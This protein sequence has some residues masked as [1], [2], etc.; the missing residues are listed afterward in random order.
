MLPEGR[1][2]EPPAR[3]ARAAPTTA[4]PA[5]PAFVPPQPLRGP[6]GA[7]SGCRTPSSPTTA[8]AATASTCGASSACPTSTHL[9]LRS[10][11]RL[12]SGSTPGRAARSST[13]PWRTSTSTLPRP[14]GRPRAHRPRAHRRRGRGDPRLRR[15]LHRL[16]AARAADQRAPAS[17]ARRGSPS[18]SSPTAPA[19]SSAAS[20]TCWPIEA[21]GTHLVVDYKTDRVPEDTTP[22]G[23]HRPQ[24][25]DPAARLRAR[26]PARRR[27]AGRGRLLPARAPRRAGHDRSTRPTTRPSW[28][29]ALAGPRAG[30]APTTSTTVTRHAAP[31]AVRRLPGPQGALQ[32]PAERDAQ[33]SAG[34][35]AGSTGPS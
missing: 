24:L 18:R 3:R 13:K 26:G 29:S 20:S 28:P 11:L 14:P 12:A 4:L 19:R 31:R 25:R 30:P 27:A 15:R 2:A 22:A 9:H 7:S 8:A 16:T 10:S 5:K 17:R 33:A 21:D 35:L 1:A 34:S 23:L 32:P 6:P